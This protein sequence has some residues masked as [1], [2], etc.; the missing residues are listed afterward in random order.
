MT[1]HSKLLISRI[2]CFLFRQLSQLRSLPAR[3]PLASFYFK[4]FG[5]E[6]AFANIDKAMIDQAIAVWLKSVNQ[7]QFYN[8]SFST[9]FSCTDTI[10]LINPVLQ[11]A[12]GP[13][14]QTLGKNVIRAL[15]SGASYHFAKPLLATEVRRILPTAAGLP[16]ELS[17]YTAAVAAAAVQCKHNLAC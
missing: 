17:L 6:I 16:M 12:T 2:V 1:K 14:V 15:L 7:D 9:S 4:L 13:S 3:T 10:V 8:T 5:Q 11:F